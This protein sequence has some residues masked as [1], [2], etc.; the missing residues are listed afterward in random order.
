MFFPS[1]LN[2]KHITSTHPSN[3]IYLHYIEYK[4]GPICGHGSLALTAVVQK[5][6]FVL[7]L[8]GALTNCQKC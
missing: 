8:T 4:H 7:L 1:L 3:I 5:S 6:L 2:S